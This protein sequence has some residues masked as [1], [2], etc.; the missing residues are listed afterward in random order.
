MSSS[1]P[2]SFHPANK[3]SVDP[4]D[5]QTV[6]DETERQIIKA[7]V[8]A[9]KGA[10]ILV[11]APCASGKTRST[12]EAVQHTSSPITYLTSRHEL[13]QD[14]R[15]RCEDVGLH[16]RTLLNPHHHCP[17]FRG[18]HGGVIQTEATELYSGGGGGQLIHQLLDL[19]CLTNC[20]YLRGWDFEPSDYDVLIGH[21]QHAYVEAVI[22][23]RTVVIDEYPGDA[24]VSAIPNPQ[25]LVTE[26]L[27][28]HDDLPWSDWGDLIQGRRTERKPEF[29]WW[30]E[31]SKLARDPF[32]VVHRPGERHTLAPLL[33]CALLYMSDLGNGF[34][35]TRVYDYWEEED[36]WILKDHPEREILFGEQ[37]CVRSRKTDQ[38]WVLTPPDFTTANGIVGLD[39]TPTQQL[40][41]SVWVNDSTI[42][43]SSHPVRWIPTSRKR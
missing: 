14:A 33:I 5:L 15:D 6:R 22:E 23:D 11:E 1:N 41:E 26:F 19:P 2:S 24:F 13:Y 37:I 18:D 10:A 29:L 34:E 42:A 21:Y 36:E 25:E 31:D 20:P 12:F 30:L 4:T 3:S 8:D 43:E 39:A 38:M 7:I 17:T 28:D 35:S 32:N 16:H 40:W 27:Q 9:S